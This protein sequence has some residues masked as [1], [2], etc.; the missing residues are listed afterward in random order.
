MDVLGAVCTTCLPVDDL[1]RWDMDCSSLTDLQ[2]YP[3]KTAT[4]R[5]RKGWAVLWKRCL[6]IRKEIIGYKKGMIGYMNLI[7]MKLLKGKDINFWMWGD[8][9]KEK[10]TKN[11]AEGQF[12]FLRGLVGKSLSCNLLAKQY[13]SYP[14]NKV[15]GLPC[16]VWRPHI[17]DLLEKDTVQHTVLHCTW[18]T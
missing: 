15:K 13:C 11:R 14:I 18:H 7:S 8:W 17:V 10:I 4:G 5:K 1:P 3:L 16:G 12:L 9:L 6:V 2:R